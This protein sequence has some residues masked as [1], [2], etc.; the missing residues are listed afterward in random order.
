MEQ[1]MKAYASQ[2]RLEILDHIQRGITNVSDIALSMGR[3]RSSIDRHLKIL[4]D[5]NIVKKV[6]AKS[7]QGKIVSI[8]TLEKNANVM[9]ATLKHLTG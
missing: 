7:K 1:I 5:A 4:V 2:A 6:Q 8:Y 9:L 3:H